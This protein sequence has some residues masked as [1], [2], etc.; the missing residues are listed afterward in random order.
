MP[1]YS[2]GRTKVSTKDRV[3]RARSFRT[4]GAGQWIDPFPMVHGT[5]PE[6]MV[7]A[8]LSFRGIQFYFLNNVTIKIPDL[9]IIKAYQADFLIPSLNLI[10]E[11]QGAQWHSKPA[12]LEA[13]ALKFAMYQYGGYKAIAWWDFD[14]LSNLE[15]L[16][17]SEPLLAGFAS[18]STASGELTPYDRTKVDSSKGIRTLNRKRKTRNLW[19]KKTV[20]VR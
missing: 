19:K 10:I 3:Q 14:I 12:A 7:Y 20:R 5:V 17:N 4:W 18:Y 9:D 2:T 16:F 13:D 15:Q 1:R 8:A 6:K 11:V